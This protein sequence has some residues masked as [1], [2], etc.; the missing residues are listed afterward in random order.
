MTLI[1]K[2]K[3]DYDLRFGLERLHVTIKL[4]LFLAR[5]FV[6]IGAFSI[7]FHIILLLSKNAISTVL[8]SSA[9]AHKLM[10]I[11]LGAGS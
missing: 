11:L 4:R 6:E 8:N 2:K 1:Q 10:E 3:N 5:Q 9:L 7:L